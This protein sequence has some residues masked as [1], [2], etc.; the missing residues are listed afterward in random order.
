MSI[1]RHGQRSFNTLTTEWQRTK[2][3]IH[4]YGTTRIGEASTL[5]D[6]SFHSWFGCIFMCDETMPNSMSFG[7]SA[8]TPVCPARSRAG[9]EAAQSQCCLP[10][11]GGAKEPDVSLAA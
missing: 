3:P 2:S 5:A 8:A 10:D 6:L 1:G 7:G 9:S 11:C 4:R